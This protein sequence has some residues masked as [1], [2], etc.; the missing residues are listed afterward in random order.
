VL[1]WVTGTPYP[2]EELRRLFTVRFRRRLDRQGY[3]RFRHWRI[4]GERGLPGEEGAV[5]LYGENLTV[6]FTEEPLAQY[7][8]AYAADQKRLRRITDPRLFETPF[9]SPQLFL[10]EH[11]LADWHLVLRLPEYERRSRSL[12]RAVQPPL[13]TVESPV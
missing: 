13:F 7:K 2:E 12:A 4:Y 11:G 6:H 10:W 5:W 3:V 8:V 1:G 9:Q